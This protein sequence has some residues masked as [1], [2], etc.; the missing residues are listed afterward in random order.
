MQSFSLPLLEHD[1]LP[2]LETRCEVVL[3]A[4]VNAVCAVGTT[5]GDFPPA[6]FPAV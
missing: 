2:R 1:I 5:S 4:D 6:E 3:E